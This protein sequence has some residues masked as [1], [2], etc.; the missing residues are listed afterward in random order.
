[1]RAVHDMAA[2][3]VDEVAAAPWILIEITAEARSGGAM[4]IGASVD[5]AS[6]KL[7]DDATGR[8]VAPDEVQS[9]IVI[10]GSWAL[11]DT[12]SDAAI[13]RSSRYS[14]TE[15]PRTHLSGLAAADLHDPFARGGTVL[16]QYHEAAQG[17]AQFSSVRVV[18]PGWGSSLRPAR[19]ALLAE[20]DLLAGP[21]VLPVVEGENPILAVLAYR[22][23]AEPRRALARATEY[24]QAV[25]V[26]LVMRDS[27][28][29][30]ALQDLRKLGASLAEP[31]FFVLGVCAAR[32]LHPELRSSQD[33]AAVLVA[34]QRA[35]SDPYLQQLLQSAQLDP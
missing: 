3:R 2:L 24:R 26:Y 12:S 5:V 28:S 14:W 13:P 34:P 7:I 22:A 30:D 6:G 16:C 4:M 21:E 15:P 17:R 29:D 9:G 11:V 20:P 31:R 18:P 32:L 19:E 23:L 10:A 33:W 8:E 35:S 27:D 1:M 25:F